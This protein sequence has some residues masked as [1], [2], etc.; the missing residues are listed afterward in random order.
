MTVDAPAEQG[1]VAGGEGSGEGSIGQPLDQEIHERRRR[2]PT[3]DDLG[4]VD[5]VVEQQIGI[6]AG[7]VVVDQSCEAEASPT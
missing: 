3:S 1:T 7:A 2:A 5:A 6:Q 4:E